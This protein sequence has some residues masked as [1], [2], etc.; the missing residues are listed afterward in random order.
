ME[1][2]LCYNYYCRCAEQ[3][4]YSQRKRVH[5]T[6][7]CFLSGHIVG[8]RTLLSTSSSRVLLQLV[9]LRLIALQ[10]LI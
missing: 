2:L 1:M 9:G 3:L 10:R 7:N 6:H 8:A 4:H 5:G